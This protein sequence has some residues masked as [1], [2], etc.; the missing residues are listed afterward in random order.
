M[1]G[2]N[3]SVCV[4]TNEWRDLVLGTLSAKQFPT[5]NVRIFLYQFFGQTSDVGY[6]GHKDKFWNAD[7]NVHYTY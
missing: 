6:F 7:M 5:Q 1:T 2:K 4:C 3:G